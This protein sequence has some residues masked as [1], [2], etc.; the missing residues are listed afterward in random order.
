MAKKRARVAGLGQQIFGAADL[1]ADHPIDTISSNEGRLIP[2]PLDQI[3]P[4][5]EQPRQHFSPEELQ[6][7]AESIKAHG[8]LQPIVVEEDQ[9]GFVILVGE[10]RWRAAQVVG[11]GRIPAVVRKPGSDRLALALI[12]NAQREDL[13]PIEEAEA[14]QKLTARGYTNRQV[15]QLVN[16]SESLISEALSLTR[17]PE[18][19]RA[20]VRDGLTNL[21]R[22]ALATIAG[23]DTHEAMRRLFEQAKTGLT[24]SEI[25]QARK[26]EEKGRGRPAHYTFRYPGPNKAYEVQVRFRKAAAT[27]AEVAAALKAALGTLA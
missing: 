9:S 14:L 12:E 4:N 21:P 13:N 24:V 3:R 25:R 20:Q 5:P 6:G 23:L 19:L 27:K 15:A 10:R 18:D 8:V 26:V 7:L 16:K 1:T 17:L 2:I 11:A 22:K